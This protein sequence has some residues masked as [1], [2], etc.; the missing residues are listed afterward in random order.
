MEGNSPFFRSILIKCGLLIAIFMF[1]VSMLQAQAPPQKLW[2]KTYGGSGREEFYI[3]QQT[4]D[5]GYILGGS[6]LSAVSG[7]K[8]QPSRG[9]N[10]YWV[11]KLDA[12]GNKLW[13]KSF[14]GNQQ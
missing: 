9:S 6:S 13:D 10:D 3:V 4:S 7:D 1:P 12:S 5:G 14:G 11:V 2:D 8:S